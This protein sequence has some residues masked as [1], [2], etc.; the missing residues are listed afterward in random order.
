MILITL[1]MSDTYCT[2]NDLAEK[3]KVSRGT[4]LKDMEKV[5]RYLE[6]QGI[7]FGSLMNKGYSLDIHE[8]ER[9]SLLVRLVQGTLESAYMGEEQEN[10][11]WK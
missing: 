5:R 7:S 11:Y 8:N 2:L 6:R 3:F 4:I 1:L 10:I 9:R